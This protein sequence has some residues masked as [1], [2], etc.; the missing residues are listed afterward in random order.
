[1]SFWLGSLCKLSTTKKANFENTGWGLAP[2]RLVAV[3]VDELARQ[4]EV[5]GLQAGE[6]LHDVAGGVDCALPDRLETP[7]RNHISRGG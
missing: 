1:L 7:G 2:H 6:V 4:P 3:K 5:V